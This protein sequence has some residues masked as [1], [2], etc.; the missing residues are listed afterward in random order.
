MAWVTSSLCMA[1]EDNANTKIIL[2]GFTIIG[3]NA[4]VKKM[5]MATPL[6]GMRKDYEDGFNFYHSQ[7]RITIERCFGVLVHR[8]AILRAPLNIPL[9]KVPPLI[10][11]LIRLHNFCIDENEIKIITVENKNRNNLQRNVKIAQKKDGGNSRLVDIDEE[12]RPVS[13]LGHG[14]HFKD[15]KSYQFDKNLSDTPM[16]RIIASIAKQGLCQPKY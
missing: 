7:L 9:Q 16:D 12:G 6:K 10:E 4:Y 5:F 2:D 3:D 15:T 8:W 1:L 11:S 13:L 14:H